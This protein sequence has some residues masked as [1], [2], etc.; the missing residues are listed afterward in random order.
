MVDESLGFDARTFDVN[1]RTEGSPTSTDG[2]RCGPMNYT[3]R[4]H[5]T[6]T[7]DDDEDASSHRRTESQNSTNNAQ[8]G[9]YRSQQT[10]TSTNDYQRE[11]YQ[12]QQSPISTIGAQ[13]GALSGEVQSALS[14]EVQSPSESLRS[15]FQPKDLV[16][17]LSVEE[18][19]DSHSRSSVVNQF[20]VDSVADSGAETVKMRSVLGDSS[21]S[22][23]GQQA[24]RM[25]S[26]TSDRLQPSACS[27]TASEI[28]EI[29]RNRRRASGAVDRPRPPTLPITGE[30][31]REE[32]RDLHQR[33]KL[34]RGFLPGNRRR[35][36]SLQ[37]S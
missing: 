7:V 8:G 3:V 9:A 5:T 11:A 31:V 27:L 14:D 34:Q 19:S 6:L 18:T 28:C 32:L 26:G 25:T 24:R 2:A 33:A 37:P 35:P 21:L 20:A 10:L 22:V 29:I 4:E 13:R 36:R 17:N 12:S 30:A 23:L 16:D 1:S 15:E